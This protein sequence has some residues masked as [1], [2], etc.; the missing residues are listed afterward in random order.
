MN[1][2]MSQEVGCLNSLV[3]HFF[4]E[5][6]NAFSVFA[7]FKNPKNAI[8]LLYDLFKQENSECKSIFWI[9]HNTAHKIRPG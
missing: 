3:S 9:S 8:C 6:K 5:K 4:L 7:Y 1:Q 2:K